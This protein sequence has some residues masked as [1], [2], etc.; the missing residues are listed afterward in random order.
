[1]AVI[2]YFLF[3]EKL[4]LR[5]IAFCQVTKK[6]TLL[7]ILLVLESSQQLCMYYKLAHLFHNVV[8]LEKL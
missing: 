2:K 8:T 1:M 7:G 4:K 5:Q 3:T 6:N